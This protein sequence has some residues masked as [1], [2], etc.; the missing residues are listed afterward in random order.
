MI[1]DSWYE[2]GAGHEV[3]EDY[4][5][6][7]Q[8]IKDEA[9]IHYA[10]LSDGCSSSSRSDVGARILCHTAECILKNYS[11]VNMR[12]IGNTEDFA[13]SVISQARSYCVLMGLPQVCL[14]CTFWMIIGVKNLKNIGM[15]VIV[16]G[17]GDGCKIQRI[18]GEDSIDVVGY[19]YTSGAPYYMNYLNNDDRTQSFL[20]FSEGNPV[21]QYMVPSDGY[22]GN[23]CEIDSES[24]YHMSLTAF[25][26]TDIVIVSDGIFTFNVDKE[27]NKWAYLESIKFKSYTAGF[28]KRRMKRFKKTREERNISHFDDLGCIALRIGDDD[29]ETA[30]HRSNCR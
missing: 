13:V 8:F 23:E 9:E 16:L 2:I 25:K 5:I 20:D 22:L 17:Y 29:F 12:Y 28:L 30:N 11:V 21:Y 10:I 26:P 15:D 7:G 6:H 14:D 18:Y 3:C 19:H 4:A 27:E 24:V 1:T